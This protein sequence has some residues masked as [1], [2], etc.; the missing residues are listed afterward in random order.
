MFDCLVGGQFTFQCSIVCISINKFIRLAPFD[1]KL[2]LERMENSRKLE[3]RAI[4]AY[5]NH[6]IWQCL[7]YLLLNNGKLQIFSDFRRIW[8]HYSIFVLSLSLSMA[9]IRHTEHHPS[10]F[11]LPTNIIKL[12]VS[13]QNF[14]CEQIAFIMLKAH[15][16]W[17]TKQPLL[18]CVARCVPSS[19]LFSYFHWES[20]SECQSDTFETNPKHSTDDISHLCP[21]TSEY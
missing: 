19:P 1:V 2:I 8:R 6:H 18:I 7:T 5:S 16:F 4:F 3:S 12:E 9:V 14:T 17:P 10:W 20:I 21:H 13:P 15:L 11:Y